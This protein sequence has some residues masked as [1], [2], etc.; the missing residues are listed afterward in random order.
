MEIRISEGIMVDGDRNLL[1]VVLHNLLGN[2]W[3][4][5]AT[6]IGTII[7][8]GVTQIDG[9]AAYFVRDNGPGFHSGD[10]GKLFIPFQRLAATAE[11]EGL[12][13]GLA[14]V[15]RIIRRHGGRIWAEAELGKGATF[16]FTLGVRGEI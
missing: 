2:A 7:E 14:T 3:K 13:I 16:Y 9:K 4:Y 15:E 6:R 11:L 1:R 8:F 12:G 5:T 10:S